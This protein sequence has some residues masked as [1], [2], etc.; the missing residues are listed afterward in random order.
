MKT[1]KEILEE[2]ELR[3]NLWESRGTVED[4]DTKV[5]AILSALKELLSTPLDQ[6]SAHLVERIEKLKKKT[7]LDGTSLAVG[8]QEY[9]HNQ[10]LDQ[11][12][13]IVK[14]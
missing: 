11:A 10:A 4:I 14:K 1:N 8:M 13:D 3:T 12:I 2:L 5:G 6:Q 9:W 7:E